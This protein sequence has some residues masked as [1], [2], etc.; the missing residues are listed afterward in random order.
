[1]ST[2]KITRPTTVAARDR[3]ARLPES[4]R[5]TV[6]SYATVAAKSA[7]SA[8]EAWSIAFDRFT[9]E[10]AKKAK[11]TKKVASAKKATGEHKGGMPLG[12]TFQRAV[13]HKLITLRKTSGECSC[14]QRYVGTDPADVRSAHAA[15]K[16]QDVASVAA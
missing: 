16:A 11:R 15:H 9:A 7:D 5:S 1:M 6:K 13:G 10:Q 12:H 14:G 3:F 2:I 8:A 4:D